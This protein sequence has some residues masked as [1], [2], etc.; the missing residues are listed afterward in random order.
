PRVLRG[1][2]RGQHL[3]HA[4][5]SVRRYQQADLVA[6]QRTE[7]AP[8]TTSSPSRQFRGVAVA[9]HH[10]LVAPGKQRRS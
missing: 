1:S 4:G 6:L 8:A 9:D 7:A 2:P 10:Q 5:H 3:G